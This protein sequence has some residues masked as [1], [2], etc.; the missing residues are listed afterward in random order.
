MH[1]ISHHCLFLIP[2]NEIKNRIVIAGRVDGDLLID[3]R[4]ILGGK[5]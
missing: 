2:Y 3:M 1:T 4:I 5:K